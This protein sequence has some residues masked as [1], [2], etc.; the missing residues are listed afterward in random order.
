MTEATKTEWKNLLPP[1]DNQRKSFDQTALESLAASIHSV[2]VIQ[3]LTVK[4]ER[5]KFRIHAGHRR[6]LAVGLLIE[7]GKATEDFEMPISIRTEKGVDLEEI[8]LAENLEREDLSPMDECEAFARLRNGGMEIEQIALKFATSEMTVRRR[9]ALGTLCDKA[10]EMV[11]SG[12]MCLREAKHLASVTHEEQAAYFKYLEDTNSPNG[13]YAAR[14]FFF[15]KPTADIAIFDI[16]DYKGGFVQDLFSD[17]AKKQFSDVDQF[18]DLQRKA[19]DE[20]KEAYASAGLTVLEP[21]FDHYNVRAKYRK[22]GEGEEPTTVIMRW[23]H[24][25]VDIETG[26]VKDKRDTGTGETAGPR[27]RYSSAQL[28]HAA[29]MRTIAVQRSLIGNRRKVLEVSVLQ[30]MTGFQNQAS[31]KPSPRI[32]KHYGSEMLRS[33]EEIAA[34]FVA[35]FRDAGFESYRWSYESGGG[36]VTDPI[37]ALFYLSGERGAIFKVIREMTD[38]ELEGLHSLLVTVTFHQSGDG[39]KTEEDEHNLVA[40]DVNA[41]VRDSFVP[42]DVFLKRFKTDRLKEIAVESG[43]AETGK[44]IEKSKKGDLVNHLAIWFKDAPNA[45]PATERHVKAT[46]WLDPIMAF[47]AIDPDAPADLPAEPETTAADDAE[48]LPEA[49]E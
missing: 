20:R 15:E 9:L 35:K 49:A 13:E 24:G 47:P 33:I 8:A 37:P 12:E 29:E 46:E 27:P 2:G 40:L 36:E 43:F 38:E 21:G 3:N 11:R 34:A 5:G 26:L 25:R 19:Y 10:K 42:D 18:M 14:R 4:K 23:Q 31:I 44:S 41:D 16:A 28:Q 17:N 39:I 30:H 32:E 6:Y 7:Q 48:A 22:A 1:K 45:E